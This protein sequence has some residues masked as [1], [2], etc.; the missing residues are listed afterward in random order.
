MKKH[1]TI[2]VLLILLGVGVTSSFSSGDPKY[3]FKV[4]KEALRSPDGESPPTVQNDKRVGEPCPKIVLKNI[5]TNKMADL[6]EMIKGKVTVII[7]MQTSN[8]GSRRALEKMNTALETYPELNVV[9]ICVDAGSPARI[10]KYIE[11]HKFP[12]TFLHDPKFTIP[13]LFGY[14]YTPT[15]AVIGKDGKVIYLD[16]WAYWEIDG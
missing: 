13:E 7:F 6:N 1:I 14:S 12:F 2:L 16:R 15:A 10:L 4:I 5:R 8:A 3:I 9:A 11:H